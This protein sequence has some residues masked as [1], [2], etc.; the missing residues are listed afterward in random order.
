M[1]PCQ[2]NFWKPSNPQEKQAR[3]SKIQMPRMRLPSYPKRQHGDTQGS[4]AWW[5]D[6][7][8]R[9]LWLQIEHKEKCF[10][11]QKVLSRCVNFLFFRI[12]KC[13]DRNIFVLLSMIYCQGITSILDHFSALWRYTPPCRTERPSGAHQLLWVSHF[14]ILLKTQELHCSQ[15]ALFQISWEQG[16]EWLVWTGWPGWG[17]YHHWNKW[18]IKN[19]AYVGRFR[20]FFC[21]FVFVAVLVSV[22]LWPIMIFE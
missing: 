21:I 11:S 10:A 4:C 15:S 9:P 6:K 16:A 13:I 19:I 7:S 3:G 1:W 2:R 17:I 20:H 14:L 18:V 22:F 8:L 5:C 12:N